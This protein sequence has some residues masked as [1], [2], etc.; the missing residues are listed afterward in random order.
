MWFCF[1]TYFLSL[2][3]TF[4]RQDDAIYLFQQPIHGSS[5]EV[6]SRDSKA[7]FSVQTFHCLIVSEDLEVECSD[8]RSYSLLNGR[9]R[10]RPCIDVF[11]RSFLVASW[12]QTKVERNRKMQG[13][14]MLQCA[15]FWI[16]GPLP[17]PSVPWTWV[18]WRSMVV[19]RGISLSCWLYPN[20]AWSQSFQSK[21][22]WEAVLPSAAI[23]EPY[24]GL[25]GK[26]TLVVLLQL[27]NVKCNN[28]CAQIKKYV[29]D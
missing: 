18:W 28:R 21:G 6:C 14:Y 19:L 2:N 22:S 8:L 9:L 23:L 3:R 26:C 24:E 12:G 15:F 27:L 5:W 11:F 25:K 10:A 29:K 1:L 20:I 17:P 13:P 7:D 4:I 16:A